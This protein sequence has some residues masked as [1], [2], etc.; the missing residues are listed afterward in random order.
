MEGLARQFTEPSHLRLFFCPAIIGTH[1][2]VIF[3]YENRLRRN[4]LKEVST[5]AADRVILRPSGRRVPTS[6]ATASF[7]S[8]VR[9]LATTRSHDPMCRFHIEAKQ[10]EPQDV[11]AVLSRS[12]HFTC[13]CTLL[14]TAEETWAVST[15]HILD[16]AFCL[17]LR[18]AA[19]NL[20]PGIAHM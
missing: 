15:P 4:H 19:D 10:N 5:P 11:L 1:F 8:K 13:I 20:F 9:C 7:F 6:G 16:S 3:T 14:P 18:H 17:P 12:V 2:L